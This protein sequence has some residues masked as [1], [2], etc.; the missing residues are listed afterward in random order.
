MNPSGQRSAP[1]RRL[2]I[3]HDG[4]GPMVLIV[5]VG[6]GLAEHHRN[7]GGGTVACIKGSG[8]SLKIDAETH[9]AQNPP[10]IGGVLRN[11]I[12]DYVDSCLHAMM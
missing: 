2:P 11:H 1:T 3:K 4:T 7:W 8:I 5:L 6:H 9:P 12:Q 10:L